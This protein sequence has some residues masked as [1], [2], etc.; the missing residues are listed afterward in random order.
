MKNKKSF[1]VFIYEVRK[2]DRAI[3]TFCTE[4]DADTFAKSN[5]GTVYKIGAY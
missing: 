1:S 3:A 4:D 5:G 2:E